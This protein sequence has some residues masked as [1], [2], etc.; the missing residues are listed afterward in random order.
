MTPPAFTVFTTSHFDREYKKLTAKHPQLKA[1]YADVLDIL[2]TDPHNFSRRHAIKKLQ[3]VEA[4]MGQMRIRS[5][6][7]RFRYDIEGQSVYLKACALRDENTY[8]R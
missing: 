4:G 7:F 8:R 3:A 5:G 1:H 2:Q 6:R